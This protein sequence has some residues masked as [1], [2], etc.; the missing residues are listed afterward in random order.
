MED[1]Y[2]I[3]KATIKESGGNG[4]LLFHYLLTLGI[5]NIYNSIESMLRAVYSE[6]EWDSNKFQGR[7]EGYWLDKQNQRY[8]LD[9]S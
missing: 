7:I 9:R 4:N 6:Y 3:S 2:S 8:F 5:L 1:W